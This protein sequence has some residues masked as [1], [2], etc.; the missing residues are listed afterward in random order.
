MR[1]ASAGRTR[2]FRPLRNLHAC[3][4]VTR[5]YRYGISGV[6]AVASPVSHEDDSARTDLDASADFSDCDDS[7][8]TDAFDVPRNLHSA[9][10]MRRPGLSPMRFSFPDESF[11]NSPSAQRPQHTTVRIRSTETVVTGG[12]HAEQYTL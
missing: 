9:P 1:C 5:Q 8:A 6:D 10:A 7:T 4:L 12:V 3:N 2:A 11:E